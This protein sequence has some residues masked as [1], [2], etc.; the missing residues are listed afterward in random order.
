MAMEVPVP[1]SIPAPVVTANVTEFLSNFDDT[2]RDIAIFGDDTLFE[3]TYGFTMSRYLSNKRD[4]VI[5]LRKA[6]EQL[7]KVSKDTGIAQTVG[8]SVGIASGLAILGGLGASVFTGGASLALALPLSEG[9]QVQPPLQLRSLHMSLNQRGQNING[10]IKTIEE[11]SERSDVK[12]WVKRTWYWYLGQGALNVADLT[13]DISWML[14]AHSQAKQSQLVESFFAG[15][16]DTSSLT[17]LL[18]PGSLSSVKAASVSRIMNANP[19]LAR[20]FA[21]PGRSIFG[22]TLVEAGKPT[23][24]IVQGT[25]AVFGIAFGIWDIV[26]GTAAIKGSDHAKAYRKIADEMNAQI[27]EIEDFRNLL[28]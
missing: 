14:L 25:F 15:M 21:A 9:R 8:G 24:Y 12:E 5:S 10:S 19:S 11:H 20:E 13:I 4:L 3:E 26:D 17:G 18:S 28:K 16:T 1:E 27:K 22:K 7:T 2:A 6:A 23:A